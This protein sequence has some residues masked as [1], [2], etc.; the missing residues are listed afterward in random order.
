[1]VVLTIP[2]RG[3]LLP[4]SLGDNPI[5]TIPCGLSLNASLCWY[6]NV[7][8]ILYNLHNIHYYHH[9]YLYYLQ[10]ILCYLSKKCCNYLH[11]EQN[12]LFNDTCSSVDGAMEA[13]MFDRPITRSNTSSSFHDDH[14]HLERT[15]AQL[16]VLIKQLLRGKLQEVEKVIVCCV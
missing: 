12:G 14:H 3:L 4:L 1:M 2:T 7:H 16:H 9:D 11:S 8:S 15:G 6:N 10:N 5:T 13:T